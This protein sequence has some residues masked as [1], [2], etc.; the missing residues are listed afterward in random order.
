[1]GTTAARGNGAVGRSNGVGEGPGE[2]DLTALGA[3]SGVS[4]D[5]SFAAFFFG[6]GS[7][8][9][10]DFFL[11][12]FDFAVGL[13]DFFGFGEADGSAV[14]LGLGDVFASLFSGDFFFAGLVEGLGDFFAGGV[15]P[16]SGVSGGVDFGL[17]FGEGEGLVLPFAFFDFG[18]A[19]D[20]GD[21]RGDSPLRASRNSWRLRA[22]SSASCPRTKGPTATLSAKAIV[23]QIRKRAT[24]AQRNRAGRVFKRAASQ[25]RLKVSR[26]VPVR[27]A[28][29][30]SI[31]RRGAERNR[32]GT[33]R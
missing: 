29:S 7:F 11:V 2:V 24:A 1:M 6:A 33:S 18:L 10:V 31:C 15:S 13:G 17:A 14:S 3:F 5:F 4:S 32:S 26:R 28:R 19:L 27:G 30:H 23:S 8:F 16:D 9:A 12:D 22:S 21:G 25:L 20:D